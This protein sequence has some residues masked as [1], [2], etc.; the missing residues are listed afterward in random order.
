MNKKY[1]YSI[2]QI[3]LLTLFLLLSINIFGY[4]IAQ[5]PEPKPG[6]PVPSLE[7]VQEELTQAEKDFEIAK[8]MFNPWYGGPLITGSGATLPQ[9]LVNVQPYLY[10]TVNYAAFD[11]NRNSKSIKN[12]TQVNP[13]LA[14]AVGITDRVD[15]GILIDW[16]H[17]KQA[18]KSSK[19]FG[20]TEVV[21]DIGIIKETPFLPG[22][23]FSISEIFPTGRYQKF[24][25]IK[26]A[27]ESTGAGAYQTTLSLTT[28]KVIWYWLTHPMN[29]RFS[30][31]YII[32]TKVSVSGFNSYGGGFGTKG[33]VDV[34]NAFFLSF[35]WEFSVYQ[36]LVIALDVAY[37]YQNIST[38]KGING[39]TELGTIAPVGSR[40]RDVLSL[41]PALEYNF[42]Q[43]LALIGGAWFSVWG[44]NTSD[45]ATG[46]VTL[47]YTF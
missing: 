21:L 9:G 37:E 30:F 33:K 42:S 40:S 45:F 12:F 20:D 19:H 35:G 6:E 31:N 13:K 26:A 17:Q 44:R 47:T 43:N 1:I 29:L 10:V 38:F 41:A 46:I 8:K 11:E 39:L 28:S 36:K 18:G 23:K 22:I 7:V 25:P 4:E 24:D 27:V 3:K 34:G 16:V 32:P 2:M 5:V 14:L 15:I